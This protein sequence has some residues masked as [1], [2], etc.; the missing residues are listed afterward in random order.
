MKMP[1]VT[2][3]VPIYNVE[4]Y[5]RKCFDSLLAQTCRDFVV[6]AV[7]DGSR[8]G[9]DAIIKEYVQKYPDLIKGIKKANGGYGSVLN[10]AIKETRTPYFLVCDADDTL[11]SN[12]VETLLNMA[13]V[14]DADICVGA[15]MLMF[16]DSTIKEY[17]AA[18][19]KEFTHLQKDTVYRTERPEAEGLWFINPSPH[20]KLYRTSLAR[21]IQFPEHVGYTD[22]MLFYLSLLKAKKVIYTD[23]PL[24][25]Y[26]INRAGNSMSDKS[27][28]AMNGEILVFKSILTQASYF[29]D[30]PDMFYYRMFE[31]FRYMLQEMAHMEG[32]DE[33]FT[34]AMD[35]LGTFLKNLTAY[36][37][38]IRS[39]YQVY[40]KV[41][42]LE[43]VRDLALMNPHFSSAAF[44]RLEKKML[45]EFQEKGKKNDE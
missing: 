40:A 37:D 21:G 32:T 33:D 3:I 34:V 26:L 18:Y 14:S 31:A 15:K 25:D 7:N 43:R 42:P 17:D 36:Q 4:K 39:R 13:R 41:R 30:V 29:K 2:I 16:A 6:Y 1:Q 5:L 9:C 23:Q 20:A 19:N 10:V 27:P 35:Y 44:A 22:N 12:A 28:A 11:E 8:D 24:A 45:T 38:A